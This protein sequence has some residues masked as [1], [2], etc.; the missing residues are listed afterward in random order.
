VDNNNGEGIMRIKTIVCVALAAAVTCTVPTAY[1][2]DQPLVKSHG[3]SNS[4]RPGPN[5]GKHLVGGTGSSHKGGHYV[6]GKKG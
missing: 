5:K 2:V 6:P 4:G 3:A 1:A